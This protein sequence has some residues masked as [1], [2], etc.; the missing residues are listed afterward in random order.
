ME[1]LRIF[2]EI[3]LVV[4]LSIR[5]VL[6]VESARRKQ[7]RFAA[8]KAAT[9]EAAA[10]AEAAAC[11]CGPAKAAKEVPSAPTYEVQ[12]IE[13]ENR[14]FKAIGERLVADKE[15]V[16]TALNRAIMAA[17]HL[18]S[19]IKKR[20]FYG[21][22]PKPYIAPQFDPESVGFEKLLRDPVFIRL[23]HGF[24]GIAT[25]AGEGIEALAKFAEK[26]E[27]DTVNIKEE[28]GDVFWYSAVVADTCETTF[29]A[30]QDRNLAKL[31]K[32]FAG[33]SYND[34]TVMNRDLKAER[35]ILE[36]DQEPK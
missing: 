32:R 18:D 31:Q 3:T 7:A 12:A 10:E 36:S 29:K 1:H 5:L 19:E 25:E 33:K 9:L 23:L 24:M 17:Q 30:E 2:F 20:C 15:S 16:A 4:L 28:L 34:K 21:K 27:V 22:E 14:D 35:E 6:M 26:G 13:L 11:R 8:K